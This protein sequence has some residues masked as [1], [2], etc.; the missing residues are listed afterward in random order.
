M[1]QAWGREGGVSGV[2]PLSSSHISPPSGGSQ[3]SPPDCMWPLPCLHQYFQNLLP[4]S[5][6]T[7]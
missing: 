1:L 5:K 3:D 2:R 7:L 4:C 6:E